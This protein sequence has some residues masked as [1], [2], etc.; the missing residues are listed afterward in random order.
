M[1]HSNEGELPR[2][3]QGQHISDRG[4]PF[5]PLSRIDRKS[6][7]P[8]LH[9]PGGIVRPERVKRHA[10]LEDLSRRLERNLDYLEENES[11]FKSAK[12]ELE[13]NFT[14][15]RFVKGDIYFYVIMSTQE[16]LLT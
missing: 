8:E 11:Y 15:L 7:P 14:F 4:P 3:S 12:R 9:D 1:S 13:Q 2:S 6:S 10:C 16:V 5:H